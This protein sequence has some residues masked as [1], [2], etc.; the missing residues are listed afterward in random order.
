MNAFD[1]QA[2]S[3]YFAIAATRIAGSLGGV[4]GLFLVARGVIWWEKALGIAI[5]LS[6]L[7]MIATVPKALAHKWRTPDA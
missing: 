3:R 1:T 7:Y 6:A 2:R 5:V 4:F